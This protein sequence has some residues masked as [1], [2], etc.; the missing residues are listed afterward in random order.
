MNKDMKIE[1]EVI[2]PDKELVDPNFVPGENGDGKG[3]DKEVAE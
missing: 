2:E 1:I 3:E